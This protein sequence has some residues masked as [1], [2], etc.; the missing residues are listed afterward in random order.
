MLL[1]YIV[2]TPIPNTSQETHFEPLWHSSFAIYTRPK[3]FYILNFARERREQVNKK[4]IVNIFK[5][6]FCSQ[7]T[8]NKVNKCV[9][10]NK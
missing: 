5:I 7:H 1:K 10:A 3:H 4:D 9:R 8:S 6:L 2:Q